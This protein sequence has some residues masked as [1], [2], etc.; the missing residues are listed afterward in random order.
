MKNV[1]IILFLI[2]ILASCNE[3]KISPKIDNLVGNYIG[4][5]NW[6]GGTNIQTFTTKYTVSKTNLEPNNLNI[7]IGISGGWEANLNVK[8]QKGN[9]TIDRQVVQEVQGTFFPIKTYHVGSGK[10]FGD[11]LILEGEYSEEPNVIFGKTYF[12]YAVKK[13]K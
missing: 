4:K 12:R 3:K 9:I 13:I 6:D 11:S 5:V 10:A 8:Y 2:N 1:I 7:T